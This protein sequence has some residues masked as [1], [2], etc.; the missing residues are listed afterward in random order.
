MRLV[1][2]KGVGWQGLGGGSGGGWGIGCSHLWWK[3]AK[4]RKDGEVM[5]VSATRKSRRWG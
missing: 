1:C 2:L 5:S 4:W 3:R